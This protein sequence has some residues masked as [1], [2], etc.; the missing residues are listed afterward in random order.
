M[1]VFHHARPS[2][3]ASPRHGPGT[4][5]RRSCSSA[6]GSRSAGASQPPSPRSE[7]AE[8]RA[9]SPSPLQGSDW[10]RS[11]CHGTAT[12]RRWRGERREE[13]A[14][15]N[16]FP[17]WAGRG[18]AS[19][20]GDLRITTGPPGFLFLLWLSA[21]MLPKPAPASAQAKCRSTPDDHR[22][23]A[24]A[25]V[26]SASPPKL[27]QKIPHQILPADLIDCALER[28]KAIISAR[29]AGKT[30]GRAETLVSD[31]PGGVVCPLPVTSL[32]HPPLGGPT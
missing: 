3:A 18:V 1:A 6:A 12:L 17:L 4:R 30:R 10:L 22:S 29:A 2:C 5:R 16:G 21:M 11:R 32:L 25:H 26:P 13:T 15:W 31:W 28:G 20:S 7:W 27:G 9:P 14:A 24:R 19:R 23:R 8:K